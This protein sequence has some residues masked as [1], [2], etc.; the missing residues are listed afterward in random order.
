MHHLDIMRENKQI[1]VGPVAKKILLLLATGARLSLTR[2]PDVYFRIL[3]ETAAE[4]GKLN[5]ESLRRTVKKLYQSKLIGC[6]EHNDGTVE[7][8]LGEEGAK[9]VLRY[10]LD[11]IEIKKPAKWDGLWRVVMF[12]IPEQKREGRNALGAKLKELGFYP[13]QKSAFILP[14]ACKDEIDF[15]VELFE[16]RPYVRMLIVKEID[17]GLHLKQKFGV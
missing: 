16:L 1:H 6:R 3:R 4:W 12:D 7:L 14:Y 15:I 9:R 2:R 8:V 13:L 17:I 10:Q 5:E 11:T